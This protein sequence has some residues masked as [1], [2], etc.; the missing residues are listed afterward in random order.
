M[1]NNKYAI[2]LVLLSLTILSCEQPIASSGVEA[3][4]SITTDSDVDFFINYD[5]SVSLTVN[6]DINISY[7]T[8]SI[9][10]VESGYVYSRTENPVIGTDNTEI[11][12]GPNPVHATFYSLPSNQTIFIRGYFKMS[13]GSTIYGNEIQTTTEVEAGSTRSI[14]MIMKPET[15]I[16]HYTWLTPML[17]VTE[18]S[19][20]SPVELGF[21]Y[22]V[23]SDFSASKIALET[24][25]AGK[26]NIFETVVYSEAIENLNEG[27]KYYIRPYIK[28]AD[29]IT[30]NGG[31]SVVSFTTNS[32]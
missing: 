4:H 23:N 9:V 24:D 15:H 22:S 2:L 3:H 10:I 31:N 17:T 28:Y 7:G 8:S 1:I 11:A 21:E 14:A 29:G 27:T 16:T 30:S 12:L 32:N 18:I 25:V 19:K 6:G 5:G 26:G 13:D 20:E